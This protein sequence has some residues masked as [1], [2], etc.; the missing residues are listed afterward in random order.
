MNDKQTNIILDF[1]NPKKGMLQRDGEDP[2]SAVIAIKPTHSTLI[3]DALEQLNSV[4]M[5]YM[6]PLAI[7]LMEEE[8]IEL[9]TGDI[10]N[11]D[12]NSLFFSLTY[13]TAPAR[14]YEIQVGSPKGATLH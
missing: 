6:H 12:K 10:I 14:M 5:E 3:A 2:N 4:L 13:P 8:Q 11:L 9:W 1:A 7:E